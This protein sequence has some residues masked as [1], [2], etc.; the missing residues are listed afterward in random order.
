MLSF[1]IKFLYSTMLFKKVN[2]KEEINK[3]LENDVE[4]KKAYDCAQRE[5]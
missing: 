1:L 4:L 3:R 2:V 5:Y